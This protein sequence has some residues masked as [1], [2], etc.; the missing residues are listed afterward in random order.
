MDVSKQMYT[1]LT[2]SQVVE[3]Y[4]SVYIRPIL[5][6]LLYVITHNLTMDVSKQMYT[7][8]TSSQVVELYVSVYI[9]PILQY[10]LYKE[11]SYLEHTW[12]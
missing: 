1:T 8:L 5:Q 12:F 11:I 9:R 6:Y 10:M 7:T 2:S 4:V 3:L